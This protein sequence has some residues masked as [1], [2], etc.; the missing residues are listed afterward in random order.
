MLVRA[1]APLRFYAFCA[2]DSVSCERFDAYPRGTH[3]PY[4]RVVSY[5]AS[6]PHNVPLRYARKRQQPLSMAEEKAASR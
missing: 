6:M 1:L 5:P 2:R 4:V 3:R